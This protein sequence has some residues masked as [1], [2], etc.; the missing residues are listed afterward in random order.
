MKEHKDS[1]D[2]KNIR[3]F[4]DNLILARR[5]AEDEDDKQLLSQLTETH[6]MLT[7]TNIF[8]GGIDTS[9]MTLNW[10]VLHMAAFQDIQDKVHQELD[11]VVGEHY[12]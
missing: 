7:L 1:F 5:E 10:A 6:L 11:S 3:D 2:R 9:R 12:Y 8:F 4:T